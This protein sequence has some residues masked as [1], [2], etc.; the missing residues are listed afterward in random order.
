M[1]RRETVTSLPILQAEI[2]ALQN[3]LTRLQRREPTAE[4]PAERSLRLALEEQYRRRRIRLLQETLA[5]ER[6]MDNLPVRTAML[7]R[8]RYVDGQSWAEV[9]RRFHLSLDRCKHICSHAL[10]EK[11][12]RA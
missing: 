7:L 1:N 10:Q 8:A 12:T 3:R 4:V 11:D 9:S 5:A 2:A 6:W